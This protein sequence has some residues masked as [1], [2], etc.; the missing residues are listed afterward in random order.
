MNRSVPGV[1][2]LLGLAL[3]AVGQLNNAAPTLL[4]DSSPGTLGLSIVVL[5]GVLFLL[6][7]VVVALVGYWAG[8][9]V[10]LPDQFARFAVTAGVAGGIGFLVGSAG[11][12]LAAPVSL[13]GVRSTVVFGI[14]YNAL[15]KGVSIGLYGLAGASIAHFRTAA[16]AEEN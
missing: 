15:V 11:V 13:S 1:F 4:R 2:A 9:R 12:L 5:G 6:S 7:T 16:N 14:G 8:Q 3:G 10:E